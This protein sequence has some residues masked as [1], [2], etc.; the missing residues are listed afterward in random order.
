M[1][2]MSKGNGEN[3]QALQSDVGQYY[4]I[5]MISF[6]DAIK[7]LMPASEWETYPN[8]YFENDPHPNNNGHKLAAYLL[9]SYLKQVSNDSIRDP[10][11]SIPSYKYSDVYQYAGIIRSSSLPALFTYADSGW[12]MS[13]NADGW[14]SLSS[15]A[16]ASYTFTTCSNDITLAINLR[17]TDTSSIRVIVD[18]GA[19]DTVINNYYPFSFTGLT[20]LYTT[21]LTATHTVRIEKMSDKNFKIDYILYAKEP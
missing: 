16:K 18:N 2:F 8:T 5:P 17:A 10:E 20:R 15:S 21:S 19:L 14:L 11:Y 9:F 6:R 7:Y 13:Y 1:L 12:Q 4:K 3:V